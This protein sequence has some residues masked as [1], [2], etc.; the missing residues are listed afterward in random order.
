M[1]RNHH[2][3]EEH[4]LKLNRYEEAEDKDGKESANYLKKKLYELRV[5]KGK[6]KEEK[7][8]SESGEIMHL[9]RKTNFHQQ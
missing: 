4:L 7:V 1:N 9:A 6:D 2:Y 5:V 8:V 3:K